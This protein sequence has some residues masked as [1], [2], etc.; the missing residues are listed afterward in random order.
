MRDLQLFL[1]VLHFVPLEILSFFLEAKIYLHALTPN[2]S[3]NANPLSLCRQ[4]SLHSAPV[5]S[6]I[7]ACQRGESNVSVEEEGIHSSFAVSRRR[8]IT[9]NYFKTRGFAPRRTQAAQACLWMNSSRPTF[10]SAQKKEWEKGKGPLNFFLLP[11][12]SKKQTGW[13]TCRNRA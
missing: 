7:K 5:Y 8:Q 3:I 4:T 10:F 9:M 12:L 13:V 2:S 6:I 11:K 1:K